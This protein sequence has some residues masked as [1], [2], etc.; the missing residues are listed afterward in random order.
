MLKD[1]KEYSLIYNTVFTVITAKELTQKV[2]FAAW[3]GSDL[4][5][6][7]KAGALESRFGGR[8]EGW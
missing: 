3:S 2:E 1:G 8:A 5:S 4:Y 7:D 6:N